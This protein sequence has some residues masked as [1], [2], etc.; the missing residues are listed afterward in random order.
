MDRTTSQ[1]LESR[2][3]AKA[4]GIVGAMTLA[5]RILGML[6]DMVIASSFGA[7]L[8]SDAF[9][10]A[11]R[12]PNFLR[13]VVAEGSL[14]T[15]FVPVFTDELH[16]SQEAA[17]KTWGSAL[18]L[19]LLITLPLTLAG[20]YYADTVVNFMA[21]GFGV[22][23][24]KSELA[25]S[26]LIVMLPYAV[27]VS[28]I[29]LAASGL[30]ALGSFALPSL[31]S[32]LLNIAMIGSI[33]LGGHLFVRPVFSLAAGV[34]FGGVV[35]TVLLL[36]E[37]RSK[38]FPLRL[39]MPWGS[40]GSRRL[41][42]LFLPALI[43]SSLYQVIVFINS[44]LASTLEEGSISWLYYAERMF[45][46]P[47][48]VFALALS[49]AALPRLSVLASRGNDAEMSREL[50][51]FLSWITVLTVPAAFALIGFA[52]PI[53]SLMYER[54]SF[55]ADSTLQTAAALSCFSVGLWTIS[56]HSVVVRAFLAKK[57]STI[58]SIVSIAAILLNIAFAL[59]L[60]GPTRPIAGGGFF[61]L[62]SEVQARLAI[63]SFGHSGIALAASLSSFFSFYAL[64]AFLPR[65]GL[66]CYFED[67]MPPIIKSFIASMFM[68]ALLKGLMLLNMPRLLEC[69]IGIPLGAIVYFIAAHLLRLPHTAQ[70]IE[71]IQE[72]RAGRREL[73]P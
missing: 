46:F 15:A 53:T 42:R 55:G 18:A 50:C 20:F 37:M 59:M 22:G 56:A 3:V 14:A 25:S 35:A 28:I 64:I 10:V 6:R 19:T 12:I 27:L 7:S 72:W 1:N 17:R 71:V 36:L 26:L 61:G 9:F 24:E 67:I 34:V 52:E 41:F 39:G 21:P 44:F 5:S 48:G 31:P 13:R 33:L 11:F 60:M 38:G 58:P 51:L 23:S 2:S 43:S 65:V 54:G 32:I 66:Q 4:T 40:E 62:I 45:Q 49:T 63:F 47:L 57:N 73:L 30:N 70:A 68:L 69:L 29:A 8:V 16:R